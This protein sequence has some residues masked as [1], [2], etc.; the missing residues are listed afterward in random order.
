MPRTMTK[1]IYNKAVEYFRDHPGDSTG[2]AKHVGIAYRTARKMW[3]GPRSK[4]WPWMEPIEEKFVREKEMQLT[5]REEREQEERAAIQREADRART[6]E[7]E[8]K[9]FEEQALNIA[10]ADIIHGLAAIN[11][12]TKGVTMLAKEVNGQLE[13][14]V[15]ARG[16]PLRVDVMKCMGII[17]SYT[18]SVRGLT[19]ATET[20]VSLGRVQRELPTTIIGLDVR[21]MTV[22][23]AE[24]ELAL[25]ERAVK[26]ARH[27]GLTVVEGEG[28]EVG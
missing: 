26:R 28:R 3:K 15:D 6:I 10:R 22:G 17:R 5:V 7:E 13:Q 14:G 2:C 9:R 27:L 21:S 4:M 25:A 1:E 18:T 16:R 19:S 24:R 23:D 20:L 11:Q 12:L 8:A